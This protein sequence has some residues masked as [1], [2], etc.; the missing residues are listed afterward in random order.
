MGVVSELDVSIFAAVYAN[1]LQEV[2]RLHE[3]AQ[4]HIE[5]AEIVSRA[6]HA[7]AD[8]VTGYRI[9]IEAHKSGATPIDEDV[10]A[11]MGL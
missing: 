5:H 2:R 4:V 3:S 10:A 8:A 6:L 1:A 9:A 11:V 7:A